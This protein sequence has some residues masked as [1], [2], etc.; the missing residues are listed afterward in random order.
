MSSMASLKPSSVGFPIALRKCLKTLTVRKGCMVFALDLFKKVSKETGAWN[1]VLLSPICLMSALAMLYTDDKGKIASEIK[2]VLKLT[3]VPDEDFHSIFKDFQSTI[4]GN[5]DEVKYI[6]TVTNKLC[7]QIDHCILQENVCTTK[8]STE[9]DTCN[10]VEDSE[11]STATI[12]EWIKDILHKHFISMRAILVNAIYFKGNWMKTFTPERI[13]TIPG[14]FFD[15]KKDVQVDMM[16]RYGYHDNYINTELGVHVVELPYV[17]KRLSMFIFRQCERKPHLAKFE[18][19]L[20]PEI[21]TELMMSIN[22][23][24]VICLYL[25]RF[26]LECQ[27]SGKSMLVAL[28]IKD[29]YCPRIAGISCMNDLYISELAHKVYFEVNGGFGEH[30]TVISKKFANVP[31][32]LVDHPFLFTIRDNRSGALLFIGR[33]MNP[34]MF[35]TGS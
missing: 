35:H 15:G 14:F 23:Q 18:A 10:F 27:F 21:L 9:R 24:K 31:V 13:T 26:K 29:V 34:N 17:D 11:V 12:D 4:V 3:D 30:T 25:P 8:H 2:K 16:Y 6:L 5:K 22:S 32:V 7:G 1:N 28:G 33:V 19:K 20:T